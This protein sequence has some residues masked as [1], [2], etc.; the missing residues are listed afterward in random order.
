MAAITPLA[1][2]AAITYPRAR[3]VHPPTRRPRPPRATRLRCHPARARIEQ[4]RR[5]I[6]RVFVER[7]VF[8]LV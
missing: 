2:L 8:E 1:S 7:V 3:Y 5:R 4:L 6:Q